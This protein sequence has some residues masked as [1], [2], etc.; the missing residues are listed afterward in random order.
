MKPK[1]TPQAL[2]AITINTRKFNSFAADAEAKIAVTLYAME[3]AK[4]LEGTGVTAVSIHQ[5]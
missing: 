5:N 1:P 3:L 2:G 4:R